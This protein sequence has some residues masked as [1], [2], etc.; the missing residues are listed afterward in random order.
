[1]RLEIPYYRESMV[2]DVPDG[3][4][5]A[6]L[7]ASAFKATHGSERDIVETALNAPVQS[8]TLA[9]LSEGKKNILVITSDHT[10]PVPSRI[11]MPLLLSHARRK[12]PHA[13]IRILVATGLHRASTRD[14]LLE[15]FGEEVYR[16][17]EI[18]VHDASDQAQMAFKGSLPSGGALWVNRLVDWA[19]LVIA[20]G[21]I[22]PHFFAGFSGGRKSILPGICSEKTVMYNHNAAF[23]AHPCSRTGVLEGNP[24]HRDMRFAAQAAGLA[25]ILNVVIDEKKRIVSAFAGHPEDAHAAGCEAVR[26]RASVQAVKADLVVVS[27]GG[28]PLDQN[29]YQAVKGMAAA[30]SCL[31]DGGVIIMIASC[32]EGHGG[33][34]FCRWFK[35]AVSPRDVLQSIEAIRPED[36][37][38]DQWEAQ[39]LARILVRCRGVIIVS[40]HI[41]PCL[42]GDMHMLHAFSFE[43][44]LEMADALL[45]E[46]A[47]MVVIPDGIGVIIGP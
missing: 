35:G 36:T 16:D 17:E 15:K 29:I 26:R 31:N 8:P 11:T 32:V 9:D 3:R 45:G 44:A 30:G 4:V 28:Y 34:G 13:H 47:A 22:E 25:F 46:K 39:I 1:M 20:E 43:Q 33:D 7:R 23:I 37:L 24:I 5:K 10:R 12:N 41:E 38:P 6:V 21:F 19:D 14:E 42:V 18:L 40:R 27:N 2:V